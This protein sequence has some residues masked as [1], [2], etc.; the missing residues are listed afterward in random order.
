MRILLSQLSLM[1]SL[2]VISCTYFIYD[3]IGEKQLAV[4]L[5]LFLF[6][7]CFNEL[8]KVKALKVGFVVVYSFIYGLLAFI[9]F[10]HANLFNSK[11][12]VSTISIFLET[13]S[14]EAGEFLH[15]YINGIHITVAFLL[16]SSL[17]ITLV[18]SLKH[19]D[20][21][22]FTKKLIVNKNIAS[23]SL[24][25]ALLMGVF[26]LRIQFLPF[27]IAKTIERYRYQQ[28]I[29][30]SIDVTPV[31]NF[32][33]VTSPATS[34][35]ELYVLVIGESTT[36]SHMSLY[37]YDRKTN[38]L[39]EQRKEQLLIYKDVIA[40]HTHTIPALGKA[41]TLGNYDDPTDKYNS[42]IIQLFNK[43][44]FKTYWIS[45]Q[46]PVGVYETSTK[47]ISRNSAVSIYTD[48]SEGAYD[49]KIIDP[50]RKV[51]SEDHPKKLIVIHLMGTHVA[52]KNR[53]PE[54]FTVFSDQPE[55]LFKNENAFQA[56]NE[57]DNAVLY[58]DYVVNEVINEVEKINS[59]SVVLYLSDHGEEVY[60][61]LNKNGHTETNGS[62]PMYDIPFVVW[63]S[64][65]FLE[66]SD[67]VTIKLDRPY[68]S[69]DLPHTLAHLAGIKFKRYVKEKSIFDTE[70]K[71]KDRMI[72][73]NTSYEEI[74][75]KE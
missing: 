66:Q 23:V 55:T 31:G 25:V 71:I 16:I 10:V 53:Y 69:E 4:Y 47:I 14:S 63:R 50:L 68:S 26:V 28:R 44:G 33:D 17:I 43:A 70:F 67:H 6:G 59:K 30:E 27:Q 13:N 3:S 18:F 11:I 32:E 5:L 72:L 7:F 1:S 40:P 19:S 52:Y 22:L 42:T 36:R 46:R 34:D 8:L 60:E 74:F 37:G 65:K 41:L 48:V 24:S 21:T 61:T 62:K 38:P 49:G 29:I 45:N 51:L 75:K 9:E 12:T 56:I 20:H 58:N 15:T 39:L 73:N 57:Y 64:E 54:D 35:T 2:I